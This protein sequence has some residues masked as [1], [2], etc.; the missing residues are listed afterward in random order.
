M[1][2]LNYNKK[3]K[4]YKHITLAERTMIETLFKKKYLTYK[5]TLVRTFI[6]SIYKIEILS[7]L[8]WCLNN[9][10]WYNNFEQ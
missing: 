10:V 5:V 2:L 6:I 7:V 8:L 9:K 4:K 1:R 3:T